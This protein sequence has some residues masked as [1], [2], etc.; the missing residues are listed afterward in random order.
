MRDRKT[1][2]QNAAAIRNSMA[3]LKNDI[4]VEI[5]KPQPIIE[6]SIIEQ[7][8]IVEPLI[9]EEQQPIVEE[10]IIEEQPIEPISL[11]KKKKN[12]DEQQ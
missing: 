1:M 12:N 9:V 8:P 11:V 6:E 4:K 7:Q 2:F 5:P 3:N 10:S